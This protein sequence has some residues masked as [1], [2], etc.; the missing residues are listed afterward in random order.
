MNGYMIYRDTA[1]V[2]FCKL[3]FK[4]GKYAGE[5]DLKTG[6]KKVYN[7]GQLSE[8][9]TFD[10]NGNLLNGKKYIYDNNGLLAA[11][12]QFKNGRYVGDGQI[13]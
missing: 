3:K 10:E 8:D 1:H 9:G 12:I 7:K 6:K 4:N 11:I 5:I 13:E 2:V